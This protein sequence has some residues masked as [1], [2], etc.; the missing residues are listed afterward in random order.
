MTSSALERQPLFVVST[1]HITTRDA[2]HLACCRSDKSLPEINAGL[3]AST[4][5]GWLFWVGDEG[6]RD[7]DATLLRAAGFSDGLGRVLERA[8]QEAQGFCYLL[9]DADGEVVEGL[10]IAQG[11]D[12]W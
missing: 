5:Y 8:Y 6:P 2:Q 7:D 11:D 9:L 10:P 1:A 4:R 3:A 12:A